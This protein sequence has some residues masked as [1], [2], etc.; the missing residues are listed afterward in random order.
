[1]TAGQD[2][3]RR[4]WAAS[5]T[6]AAIG[7]A[8][9]KPRRLPSEWARF[10]DPATE[11]QL[12]RLTNPAC[13]SYLPA[14]WNRSISRRGEFLLFWS[15]RTGSPQ[16]FHMSLKN[17]EL[18]QA[19]SMQDLDGASIALLPDDRGF[20][21]FDGPSLRLVKLSNFKEKEIYR[22]PEGW[23]GREFSLAPDGSY[24]L[25]VEMREGAWRL[26]MIPIAKGAPSTLLAS[27]DPLALPLASPAGGAI[28]YRKGNA[29]RWM[30]AG[31]A[32]DR[33]LA[34][35]PGRTGPAF[36]SPDGSSVL[37]L[38]FP[39][40]KGK[41]NAIR[42]LNL[43]DG[44]DR[45]IS[46]TTQYIHFTPNADASVFA[47]ASGS[48]AS[49][50]VLLLLRATRREL[51]ICEHRAAEPVRVTTVF[52]PD[53]QSV[54]FQSDRHGKLALYLASVASLVERTRL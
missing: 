52:S 49:P 1:M 29:L 20:C 28:L 48:P 14:Y 24:G 9:G 7:A 8:W 47:G 27:P 21:C 45:M 38:N 30:R 53:S 13:S 5:L 50:Y 22:V 34:L 18:Q 39:E 37:Y 23:R 43:A 10:P 15:D 32:D 31:G 51:T 40:E 42:E 12:L 46:V 54:L 17:G 36:W 19:A 26:R 33:T 44:T 11:F 35:A 6:A 4:G 3:T 41:L 2:W 25:A 16:V